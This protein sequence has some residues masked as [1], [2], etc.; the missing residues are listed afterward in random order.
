L[1]DKLNYEFKNDGNWWMKFDDWRSNYNKV[2]VT[3]IFPASW[4]L[5]GCA[6]EWKGNTAGGE[7]P[8]PK[9]QNS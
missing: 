5:Y 4:S 9:D 2:Y 1:K 6:G 7:Y 8:F 3:K